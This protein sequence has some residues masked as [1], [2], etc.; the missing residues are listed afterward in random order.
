M[1]KSFYRLI[2]MPESNPATAK[3]MYTFAFGTMIEKFISDLCKQAG[4]YDNTSVKFWDAS[5]GVSGELDIVV[6]VPVGDSNK[7][8]IVE[9][10]STWGGQTVNG[11]EAGAAK[12]LFYHPEGRGKERKFYEGKAKDANLLQ[13]IIYLYNNR[14]DE[15]LLGAKLIYMLRDNFARTE[16]DIVL[17]EEEKTGKY[18]AMVNGKIDD[19]FYV[20]DIYERFK[21]LARYYSEAKKALKDGKKANELEYPEREFSLT[22]SDELAEELFNEGKISKS[23]YEK[24]QKGYKA[25]DF[26]CSYCNYKSNCWNLNTQIPEEELIEELSGVK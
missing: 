13:T 11:Y 23:K 25:G 19:R 17:V 20:E 3:S 24:H 14:E 1:R 4:I 9:S 26:Q 10:K 21:A 2:K 8:I 5:S 18:R 12:E 7:Y 6:K 15:D 16:F 22:Y